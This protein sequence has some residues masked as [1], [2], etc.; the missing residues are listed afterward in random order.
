MIRFNLFISNGTFFKV[1][2]LGE[3]S[4]ILENPIPMAKPMYF[5]KAMV[6]LIDN[7]RADKLMIRPEVKVA[8]PNTHVHGITFF[9]VSFFFKF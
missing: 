8:T 5:W 9:H 7:G 4:Q 2:R 1:L 3:V 6:G